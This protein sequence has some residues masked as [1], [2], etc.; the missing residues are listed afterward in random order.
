MIEGEFFHDVPMIGESLHAEVYEKLNRVLAWVERGI[1]PW[2]DAVNRMNYIMI[3][4]GGKNCIRGENN[5]S[6][7]SSLV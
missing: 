2:D 7:K 4:A 1:I 6:K 3:Q 5:G